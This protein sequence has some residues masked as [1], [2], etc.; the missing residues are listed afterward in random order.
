MG[1]KMCQRKIREF[2]L[3]K[4]NGNVSSRENKITLILIIITIFKLFLYINISVFSFNMFF[5][6]YLKR[7]GHANLKKNRWNNMQTN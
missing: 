5:Q 7:T 4:N 1:K 6:R 2:R 3:I